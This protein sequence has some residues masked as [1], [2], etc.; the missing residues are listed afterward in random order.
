[1]YLK[2]PECKSIVDSNWSEISDAIIQKASKFGKNKQL[3]QFFKL[4]SKTENLSKLK[5]NL[6]NKSFLNCKIC[7]FKAIWRFVDST[8]HLSN[9]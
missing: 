7:R 5:S 1:M 8:P 4:F 2:Y 9:I 6:S 3:Q